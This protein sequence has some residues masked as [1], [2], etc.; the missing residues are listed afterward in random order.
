MPSKS[1]FAGVYPMLYTFFDESGGVDLGPIK[2][3]VEAAIRHGVDGIGVLGLATE[4]NKLSTAERLLVLEKTAE[5][6]GGRVPLSVTIA[7]S[8]VEGQR[9]F[10]KSALA[11][12]ARWL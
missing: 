5:A 6:I 9:R 4:T 2:I 8:T 7:E 12:G 11:A 3:Q 10:A 1:G